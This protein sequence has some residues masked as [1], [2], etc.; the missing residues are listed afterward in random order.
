M[1]ENDEFKGDPIFERA[2]KLDKAI[3]PSR[4]LWPGIERAIAAPRRSAWDTVWAKAA[5]ALLL[6]GGSSGVTYFAMQDEATVV[7]EVGPRPALVFTPVSGSFGSRYHLGPDFQDARQRLRGQLEAELEKLSPEA[8]QEVMSNIEAIQKAIA[9]INIALAEEPDNV[10]LQE[11]LLSTYREELALMRRVD[12]IANA[13]MLR[14]D[15]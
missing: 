1:N 2:A 8:Q 12:G 11:L 4:D 9:D 6:V 13:A 15:I 14:G 10:L 7:T 5:M 3:A